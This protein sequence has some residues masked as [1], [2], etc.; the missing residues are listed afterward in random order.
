MS[1]LVDSN[2]NVTAFQQHKKATDIFHIIHQTKNISA[3]EI[4]L[5][6]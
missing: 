3:L 6:K 2:K 5:I 4:I 1:S